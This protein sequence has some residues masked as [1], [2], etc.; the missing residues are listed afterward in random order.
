MKKVSKYLNNISDSK[1]R[2]ISLLTVYIII[3]SILTSIK[4]HFENENEITNNYIK[5]K[6][7][8][9]LILSNDGFL[10]S[11]GKGEANEKWKIFIGNSIMPK[12]ID[13]HKLTEKIHLYPFNDKLYVL[14][15]NTFVSFDMFVKELINKKAITENNSILEGKIEIRTFRINLITGEKVDVGDD[16]YNKLKLKKNEIILKKV[17]YILIKKEINKYDNYM[18]ISLSDIV[19]KGENGKNGITKANH[20]LNDVHELMSY[21]RINVDF[22]KI[23]SVH[24]YFSYKKELILIYDKSLYEN[25]LQNSI[26]NIHK[27]HLNKNAANKEDK[28]LDVINLLV[29]HNMQSYIIFIIVVIL[30]IIILFFAMFKFLPKIFIINFNKTKIY[31][32]NYSYHYSKEPNL[33]MKNFNNNNDKININKNREICYGVQNFSITPKKE[34]NSII[35]KENICKNTCLDKCAN[36]SYLNPLVPRSHSTCNLLLNGDKIKNDLYFSPNK[37]SNIESNNFNIISAK[38]SDSESPIS[39]PDFKKDCPI[40]HFINKEDVIINKKNKKKLWDINDLSEI[41]G[42]Y[43]LKTTVKT[44]KNIDYIFPKTESNEGLICR[45][46]YLLPVNKNKNNK[47][48]LPAKEE[49]VDEKEKE[50][51]NNNSIDIDFSEEDITKKTTKENSDLSKISES[52]GGCGI[53]D[54]YTEEDNKNNSINNNNHSKIN[55]IVEKSKNS[56]SNKENLSKSD[57]SFKHSKNCKHNKSIK[58][59]NNNKIPKIRNEN[60]MKSRLDK[61]FKDLEKIGEGGF[62]IVLKGIHRLDKG[63]CAIKIIKLSSIN[64]RESIINEAITMTSIT[65]KHIVQYKTCWIDNLLGSASKFFNSSDLETPSLNM[66]GSKSV[67]IKQ[68]EDAKKSNS[69]NKNIIID[70]EEESEDEDGNEYGDDNSLS[71][72]KKV[73]SNSILNMK[74]KND[75]SQEIVEKSAKNGQTKYYCNYRDD[76]KIMTKSII[77]NKYMNESK[78]ESTNPMNGEY[79]FILMEYC[80]GLTLEKYIQQYADKS[81]ERKIIYC[82]TSQILKSLVKIHSGGIIHRDIKPSNIFIKNDQLKI[83]DFG[84]ATRYTNS[85]KLLKSKKI[86]GTPLYLSPE[87]TNFKTYNE[88]VDI[89]ACGITLYEMCS[90]FSTSMERYE[91]IMNLRNNNIIS[92][93]VNR[94]YPEEAQIIKLMTKNDYNE[95]PSAKEILLSELFVNLGKNLGY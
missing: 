92:E 19:I 2:M 50:E 57:N 86:E 45:C 8:I 63:L 75:N 13:S 70:D 29:A 15:E 11:F 74:K 56:I 44:E 90:C 14:K 81:I 32:K 68:N 72:E 59:D 94:N 61:D 49:T 83:G 48:L 10:Y 64:D 23:V 67:I 88:K 4:C 5:E 51:E 73:S 1:Y 26:D 18:N 7:D 25:H 33:Q 87:Q 46:K 91:H 58:K 40:F 76:S 89:Y 55:V 53:W 77:S 93:K 71:L 35:K 9:I 95:R 80:D 84:L 16:L 28:F 22:K 37:N 6:S 52:N 69:N 65:S 34:S 30:I 27:S 20:N 42:N 21:F 24:S 78:S 66:N 85:S 62:G 36:V 79:F 17:E 41:D 54:D 38:S 39:S 60:I 3:S 12:N 43:I 47:N 82:F 31:N